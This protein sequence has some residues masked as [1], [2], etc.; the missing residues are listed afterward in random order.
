MRKQ[1]SSNGL[2]GSSDVLK[3][4]KEGMEKKEREERERLRWAMKKLLGRGYDVRVEGDGSM[5]SRGKVVT[6]D[7]GVLK[8]DGR[9]VR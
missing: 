3:G 5:S 8:F 7:C 2:L 1:A 9:E 4:L 6:V